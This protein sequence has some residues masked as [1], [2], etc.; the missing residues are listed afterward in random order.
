MAGDVAALFEARDLS[1]R[2]ETA[3]GP[4][5]AVREVSF[6]V[7]AGRCLGLVGQ[8]GSGKSQTCLGAFGLL[9]RNGNLSGSARFAGKELV[10]ASAKTLRHLRGQSIGFVFQD[11][12]TA[13]TPHLSVGAQMIETLVAHGGH[14]KADALREAARL[15]E[16]CRVPD[17]QRRLAQFPHELSGGLRQRVMIAQAIALSPRLLI[18]DEPTTALDVSVQAQVLTLLRDL[19]EEMN[20][21]L[22]LISHDMGVIAGLADDVAVMSQGRIIEQG[23]VA[24]IF[25]SPAEPETRALIDA[26][27]PRR[28]GGGTPLAADASLLDVR[29]LKVR[30]PVRSGWFG[31]K[32]LRAVDGVDLRIQPGEVVGLV[33]ESGCGKSTLARAILGLAPVHSGDL[34]WR[35]KP[36][37]PGRMERGLRRDLQIVFQDPLA[38][39]DPRRTIG[40]AIAEPLEVFEPLLSGSA[41]DARVADMMA[42]VGLDPAWINRYPHE[43]SGGQN[44]RVGIARAL[45]G[46][47]KLL[48]ADEAISALDAA[49][50]LQVLDLMNSLRREMGIA[51]LFIT[52]DLSA[53]QALCDRVVV[54]FLGRVVESGPAQSVLQSPLHPY[55][56]ALL[57]AV[58]IAD[59]AV[60]RDR[61]TQRLTGDL[62]SPIDSRAA[63]RYFPSRMIDDADADQPTLPLVEVQPGHWVAE[64]VGFYEGSLT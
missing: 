8:S 57:A 60:Q 11:P 35:E 46:G 19:Q 64:H 56:R 36:L 44:Q 15:L 61:L 50:Q 40:D 55:T 63:M 42:R 28:A 17:A 12:L 21:A 9:A 43:F 59:P 2:F 26:R 38:S 32:I 29:A 53:V 48:I 24:G 25:A 47:P 13:L 4:V 62:P 23:P 58:P 27:K 34:K 49:T 51:I 1:V 6:A 52:H 7:N 33:G 22:I 10:G 37:L 41:R 20:M 31:R 16:R 14:S 5:D 54:L 30:F 45:I 39:L 3:D 18:A